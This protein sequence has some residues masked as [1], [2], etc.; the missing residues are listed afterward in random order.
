VAAAAAEAYYLALLPPLS[1]L[2]ILFL[3][4]LTCILLRIL[5]YFNNEKKLIPEMYN[6]SN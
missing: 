6:Q 1:P 4:V 2:F 5:K 3:V